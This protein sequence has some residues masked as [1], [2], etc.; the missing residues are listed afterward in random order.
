MKTIGFPISDKENELRR[1]I[2]PSDLMKI[3][4]PEC[5]FIEKEYGKV[6]GIDDSEYKECG[7]H[8]S[9]HYDVLEQDIICDA[10]IG[11]A[12]YLKNIGEG[13][14]IFGWV[15]AV[16]NRDI[17]D[18]LL[19]R[20]LTVYAWEDMFEEGRHCFWRNNEIAGEAAIMHAFQCY[21]LM[22][23][24]TKVALLGRGNVA[25]GALKIL[26]LLGAD[27]TVYNRKT[28]K[29]F[30]KEMDKYDVIVNGILWD[31]K[32][33]D[34]IV[35][36]K[37]LKK[38]K[39]GS[40]IIDISCDSHGGIETSEPTTIECPIY[41]R[42]GILHYVVD[43][44]PS[45]FYKT[46]SKGISEEVGKYLDDLCKE[47]DNQILKQALIMDKGEIIDKRIIDFQNR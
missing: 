34:H 24:N 7:C 14:T 41:E 37:D 43:H 42:E 47:T 2:L 20:K 16:Q 30:K 21:G 31:T 36:R 33:K 29:L 10:K 12:G 8:I 28:E 35:Y 22:P 11:D 23:Y 5:V 17:T 44:T 45:L 40:M 32:R 38:M 19:D 27:V 46:A 18:V 25:R 26:T 13:K 4:H 15:H 9:D 39:K 6:L 1:A 3:T